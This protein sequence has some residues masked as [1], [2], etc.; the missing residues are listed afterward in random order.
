[1]LLLSSQYNMHAWTPSISGCSEK[2]SYLLCKQG[3]LYDKV[4]LSQDGNDQKTEKEKLLK[5]ASERHQC[6]L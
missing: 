2:R 4:P 3:L 6:N 5:D 1:M